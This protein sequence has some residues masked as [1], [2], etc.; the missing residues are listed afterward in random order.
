[1]NSNVSL[2][3]RISQREEANREEL[4]ERL[5]RCMPEDGV[6]DVLKGLRLSRI[7]TP[8]DA[9]FGLAEPAFCTIAQGR[10]VTS[11]GGKE[12]PYDPYSYLL[13]TVELPVVSRVLEATKEKP[14]LGF[15][16]SLDP[17]VVG[18]VMMEIGQALLP[19]QG[20]QKALEVSP[21]DST[22]LD[23]VL[24]LVRLLESPLEARILY[25]SV[26]REIVYRL[27]MGEQSHRMHQMTALGGHTHRIS[28]AVEKICREFK[29]PLRVEDVARQ[30]GMSVSG[31]HHHFKA[32]TAMSPLQFQ[33]NLRLQEAR[34]LMLDEELDAASAGYRVGYD[35][36]SY[37][38]REYKSLF[39][40]P[41]KRDIEALRE[42]VGVGADV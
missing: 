29:D 31:F 11:L 39:G 3:E 20:A 23:G 7:S 10:K 42:T 22:L 19:R 34:R 37:F 6:R 8:T 2:S 25:P 5:A 41:P 24:R 9:V 27:L 15:R 38:N 14:Y 12:Y 28:Q 21:L 1:M 36:A 18:S 16:L 30:I 40:V 32:V 13:A 17:T 4:I 33:K 26:S 35:D